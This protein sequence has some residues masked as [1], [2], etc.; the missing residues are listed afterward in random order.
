MLKVVKPHHY[1]KKE[2]SAFRR[3]N[4][5]AILEENSRSKRYK[6]LEWLKKGQ[7]Q[8]CA[9]RKIEGSPML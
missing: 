4:S 7:L 3:N 8:G 5:W 9:I 1:S 2:K 6:N